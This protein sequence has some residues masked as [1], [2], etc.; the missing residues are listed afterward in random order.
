MDLFTH[1]V[2]GALASPASGG[3]YIRYQYGCALLEDLLFVEGGFN[4]SARD[5]THF[6]VSLFGGL[7]LL[8]TAYLDILSPVFLKKN[9]SMPQPC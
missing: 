3:G 6:R 4:Q 1:N 9:S 8:P 5:T 7:Y 2:V